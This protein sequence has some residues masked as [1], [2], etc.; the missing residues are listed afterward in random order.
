AALKQQLQSPILHFQNPK[1]TNHQLTHL[2]HPNFLLFQTQ[3]NNH[4]LIHPFLQ[5]PFQ[6]PTLNAKQ[7]LIMPTKQDTY[8][9]DFIV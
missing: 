1:P 3:Q 7:Y 9:K 6:I 8:C 5:H 4:S 2:H